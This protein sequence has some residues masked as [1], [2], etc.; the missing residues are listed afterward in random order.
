MKRC[1]HEN[2][3]H[4]MP[5]DA[6]TPDWCVQ[7][8]AEVE[9]FRCIDCGA[10]LSLGPS[11][12]DSPL[13]QLE[14]RLAELLADNAQLWEPSRCRDVAENVHI[15]FALAEIERNIAAAKRQRTFMD[16]LV[17]AATGYDRERAFWWRLDG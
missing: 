7:I 15:D 10:W 1:K 3:E 2:A 16:A 8:Y 9:Q 5:G 14:I 13:V 12:D 11:N 4:M 17:D 6:S